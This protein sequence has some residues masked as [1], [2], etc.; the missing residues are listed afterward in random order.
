MV[1]EVEGFLW[2]RRR[3]ADATREEAATAVGRAMRKRK[4]VCAV[5][6]LGEASK[7]WEVGRMSVGNRG[8]S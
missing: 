4:M 3:S 2:M 5:S 6:L 7:I 8:S 1:E